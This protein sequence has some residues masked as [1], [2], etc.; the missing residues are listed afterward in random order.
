MKTKIWNLSIVLCLFYAFLFIGLSS[1]QPQGFV[2]N[3]NIPEFNKNSFTLRYDVTLYNVTIN[4]RL[5][6]IRPWKEAKLGE[7]Y[8]NATLFDGSTFHV[9]TTLDNNT[10][11]DAFPNVNVYSTFY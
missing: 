7:G 11:I 9:E 4:P 10:V 1:A 3:L 5:Y 6:V 2:S 8:S